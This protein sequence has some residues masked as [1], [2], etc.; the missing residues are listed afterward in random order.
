MDNV[1]GAMAKTINDSF[2]NCK[3]YLVRK[4]PA[5]RIFY[6]DNIFR[7]SNILTALSNAINNFVRYKLRNI[8]LFKKGERDLLANNGKIASFNETILS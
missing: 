6:L 3:V 7:F 8:Y 1:G 5:L 2:Q 4:I